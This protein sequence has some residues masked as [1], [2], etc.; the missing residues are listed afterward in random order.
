[1]TA[2]QSLVKFLGREFGSRQSKLQVSQLNLSLTLLAFH[3]AVGDFLE[4]VN[5]LRLESL[6]QDSDIGS[7]EK[8]TWACIGPQFCTILGNHAQVD[9][10]GLMHGLQHLPP[11]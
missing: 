7:S 9:V 3:A 10:S 8:R 2:L 5:Y 1:M 6:N 11:D 4:F